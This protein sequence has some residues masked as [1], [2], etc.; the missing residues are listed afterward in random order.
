MLNGFPKTH[1]F[2]L[3]KVQQKDRISFSNYSYKLYIQT[4]Y[5]NLPK[6]LILKNTTTDS[7]FTTLQT[8]QK[9]RYS[10]FTNVHKNFKK[11]H[12]VFQPQIPLR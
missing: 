10:V 9:G 11:K 1:Q 8:L 7:F 6:T 3:R 4:I 5:A 12:E 2:K